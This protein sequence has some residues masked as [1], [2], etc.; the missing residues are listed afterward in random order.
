MKALVYTGPETIEYA[1]V[2]KPEITDHEVLMKIKSVG[3]CGTD[4]HIYKG[5][6]N[7]PTPLVMGHEFSGIVESV[8][9]AVTNLKVGDRVVGEHVVPCRVCHYCLIGKPN[10]CPNAK[11]I[12]LHRAGALAEYLAIPAD[13]V[14]A[15]PP[16]L[17]FDEAAL[18]EPLTIALYAIRES[19]L[20]LDKNVAVIGQGPIGLLLDQ[21]VKSAG[22]NVIGIETQAHRLAFAADKKWID[23]AIDASGGNVAAQIEKQFP[24]GV[25]VAIE[26]VGRESTAQMALDI[27]ARSGRVLLL[28]VF[29]DPSKLDLMSIVKK[30]LHVHGSWTCA[31]SFPEA[32]DL[33]TKGKIDLTSLITHRYSAADGAQAFREALEYSDGRVKTVINFA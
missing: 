19:G 1:D 15:I 4:L 32:I 6:M 26:A 5:K 11:V 17:G 27:A 14:Y 16:S 3:I 2:P 28:G 10:L 31:F 30:E 18:I 7:L 29:E 9:R 22:G 21:A 8:G 12:G 20:L 25:D 13:L 23:V 33:V 24:G